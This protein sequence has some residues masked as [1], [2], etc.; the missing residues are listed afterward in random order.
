MLPGVSL[1]LISHGK[2]TLKYN[3]YMFPKYPVHHTL[4]LGSD[5]IPV[6]LWKRIMKYHSDISI[7]LKKV[8][9]DVAQGNSPT[10][11]TDANCKMTVLICF[12]SAFFHLL[13]H[14]GH[15]NAWVKSEP[16]QSQRPR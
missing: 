8:N 14:R 15:R 6:Y 4:H 9:I 5:E 16:D 13:M 11:T 3:I 12:K 1:R 7:E 10:A 2:D